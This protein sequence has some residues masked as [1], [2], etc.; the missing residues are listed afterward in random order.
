M[1]CFDCNADGCQESGGQ[2]FGCRDSDASP[3]SYEAWKNQ[4]DALTRLR[5]FV[6]QN[7]F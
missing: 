7:G 6:E 4:D 1:R 5:I 2:Y 3:L